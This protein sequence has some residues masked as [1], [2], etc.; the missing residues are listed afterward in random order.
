MICYVVYLSN[1]LQLVL[2]HAMQIQ[3]LFK[4]RKKKIFLSKIKFLFVGLRKFNKFQYLLR[5]QKYIYW[6]SAFDFYVGLFL[7]CCW[8]EKKFASKKMWSKRKERCFQLKAFGILKSRKSSSGRR[9]CCKKKSAAETIFI[10]K[11]LNK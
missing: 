4:F 3:K 10:C 11:K 8:L 6:N 7:N 1:H 5:W 9:C 2:Y